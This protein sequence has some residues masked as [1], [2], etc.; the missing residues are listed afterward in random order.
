MGGNQT[1][2]V[3]FRLAASAVCCLATFI[4]AVLAGSATG[5]Y[6]ALWIETTLVTVRARHQV[7]TRRIMATEEGID[8]TNPRFAIRHRQN[9]TP[10]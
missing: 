1:L 9:V 6:S 8:E 2:L 10:G 7:A 5:R 3:M 4:R